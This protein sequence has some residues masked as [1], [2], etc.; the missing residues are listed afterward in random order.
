MRQIGILLLALAAWPASAATQ[1]EERGK[2][3]GVMVITKYQAI[4]ALRAEPMSGPLGEVWR[5]L[6]FL[7]A[8]EYAKLGDSLE[9]VSDTAKLIAGNDLSDDWQIEFLLYTD[10]FQ[11]IC[12]A[13]LKARDI[14]R[15]DA[16]DLSDCFAAP[17]ERLACI[18]K[19]IEAMRNEVTQ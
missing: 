13:G 7:T 15:F 10:Y 9:R 14:R 11:S 5:H 19:K 8:A 18:R 6:A 1:C 12:D 17:S 2:L 3:A 16:K 4:E